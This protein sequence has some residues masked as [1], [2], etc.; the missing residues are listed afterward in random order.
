MG[1][2]TVRL[3]P[4]NALPTAARSR[5]VAATQRKAAP[6]PILE[7]VPADIG[8][9]V[10]IVLVALCAAGVL[11]AVIESG[12]GEV[13]LADGYQ[14][15]STIATYA[16]TLFLTAWCLLSLTRRALWRPKLPYRAGTYLFPVD[17]VD[18]S[19]PVLKVFPIA[20]LTDLRPTRH[21]VNGGYTHTSFVLTFEGGTR[22]TF[23]VSN[24]RA[25]DEALARFQEA[26]GRFRQAAQVGD[27]DTLRQLDVF[28]D[29]KVDGTW[30]YFGPVA[31]AAP[32]PTPLDAPAAVAREVPR[33]LRQ[34]WLS[35]LVAGTLAAG[36]LWYVRNRL[37][38]VLR[39]DAVSSTSASSSDCELYLQQGGAHTD[40]VRARL[41]PLAALREATQ[42][43]NVTA[44]RS[45]LQRYPRTPFTADARRAIHGHFERVQRTYTEQAA[46]SDPRML[47]FMLHMLQFMEEHDSPAVQVRFAPPSTELLTRADDVLQTEG[48]RLVHRPVA[49]IAGQ[50][51]EGSSVPREQAIT[52]SLQRAFAVVFPGDILRLVHG[53]RM[54]AGTAQNPAAATFDVAYTVAPSG[55]FYTS[56]TQPRAFVGIVVAFEVTMRV[57]GAAEPYRFDVTVLPPRHFT[58]DRSRDTQGEA[59]DT[60]VYA[61]MAER[62][63]DRLSD[64]FRGVFF[65][66]GSPG[67]N[68]GAPQ[69]ADDAPE[70][71]SEAPAE[72]PRPAQAARGAA[73]E[74][75]SSGRRPRHRRR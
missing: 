3:V 8:P 44:L 29:C 68:G 59:A 55:S 73:D 40:E 11:Y 57:P 46:T 56:D 70:E 22:Y 7:H 13:R 62:A 42:R 61:V 24:L 60:L 38:D 21:F 33:V 47:P 16:V 45:Y 2:P 66:P 51:D 72:P 37:S 19:G 48:M 27:M 28:F 74:S 5:F 15:A 63:F 26:Q 58:V 54:V 39:F 75:P 41:L 25:G 50:F 36:P 64:R 65:R 23:S 12:F 71:P 4:F 43:Q 31:P 6:S 67:F 30:N 20:L 17:L 14:P 35:A 52:R 1:S 69:D 32:T 49:P 34:A 10:G 18:A 53:G 9:V